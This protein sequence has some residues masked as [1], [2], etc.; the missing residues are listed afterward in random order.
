MAL[1]SDWFGKRLRGASSLPG[2]VDV[3]LT[4]NSA[5]NNNSLIGVYHQ[6]RAAGDGA[7]V[8][9]ITGGTS[10]AA[11]VIENRTYVPLDD[12]AA[13]LEKSHADARAMH[14]RHVAAAEALVASFSAAE[15]LTKTK[16]ENLFVRLQSDAARDR[17]TSEDEIRSLSVAVSLLNAELFNAT[18]LHASELQRLSEQAATAASVHSDEMLVMTSK[19]E[20]ELHSQAN[21]ARVELQSLSARLAN[22]SAL[23][24]E[25]LDSADALRGRIAQRES[26]LSAARERLSVAESRIAELESASQLSE[27][28]LTTALAELRDASARAQEAE[29]RLKALNEE[30]ASQFG[31][32]PPI[33]TPLSAEFVDT[34]MIAVPAAQAEKTQPSAATPA[35]IRTSADTNEFDELRMAS[36]LAISVLLS[37]GAAASAA[38]RSTTANVDA[39]GTDVD[40]RAAIAR[41]PAPSS[42]A[43][44]SG[45]ALSVVERTLKELASLRSRVDIA[46]KRSQQLQAELDA[47]SSSRS[48]SVGSNN[49]KSRAQLQRLDRSESMIAVDGKVDDDDGAFGVEGEG[50]AS[51]MLP[52]DDHAI[53]STVA[54]SHTRRSRAR[55]QVSAREEAK[56]DW[57][58][59]EDEVLD[60]NTE[61]REE[62]DDGPVDGDA[63]T[64]NSTAVATDSTKS[65][66]GG[67]PSLALA[68]SAP[69]APSRGTPT[70]PDAASSSSI[71]KSLAAPAGIT[72]IKLQTGTRANAPTGAAAGGADA[73]SKLRAAEHTIKELRN[74]IRRLEAAEAKASAA[75]AM[76]GKA[77]GVD[78]KAI[79]DAVEKNRAQLEKKWKKGECVAAGCC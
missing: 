62:G 67:E 12:A 78:D 57:S 7:T 1:V 65:T 10:L 27:G 49:S 69:P 33:D 11:L 14:A 41:V 37:H 71:G 76:G 25:A 2:G 29:S 55:R 47:A 8:I 68:V 60:D 48:G 77:P 4:A 45:S 36:A 43:A 23:L 6:P 64:P 35:V 16:F 66:L 63:P 53:A 15:K 18:A 22:E 30:L 24:S 73:Q 56:I 72:P 21:A 5:S 39:D 31:I 75:G 34:A 74:N 19:F 40:A 17:Q 51:S 79:A 13:A 3:T 42:T 20:D 28:A 50:S 38:T 59:D 44:D 61:D 52:L 46:E 9:D 70:A 54:V 32:P 58:D 26:D